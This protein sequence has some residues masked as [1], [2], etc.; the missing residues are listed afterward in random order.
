MS[1]PSKDITS[2]HDVPSPAKLNLFLHVVGQRPDGYHLLQ[3]V[4]TFIDL[5]DFLNFDVRDDG[6][7]NRIDDNLGGG[8]HGAS[9]LKNL[10]PE[11]DLVIKAAKLLQSHTGTK[12]GA[13]IS[14]VKNIP[15]GGGLGG[16]SSNAATTLIALNRLWHTGLNRTQL[17]ELG[18]QLGAD[19]PIFIYGQSAFAQGIGDTFQ[20]VAIPDTNY[21]IVQPDTFVDTSLIFSNQGLTRGQNPVTITDF[22]DWQKLQHQGNQNKSEYF[23]CNNLEP[24][25]I[26]IDSKILETKQ[27]LN[28]LGINA[29]LTGSGACFFVVVATA[30]QAAI[31]QRNISVRI[32]TRSGDTSRIIKKT[33]L[34]SGLNQHPLMHWVDS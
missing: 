7:I 6:A 23:G 4:F 21:L 2:L 20:P 1:V 12:F 3:T 30:Q 17:I 26:K 33:W 32:A 31:L 29:R 14:Y 24:V 5:C 22:T 27:L 8:E 16:G 25:A 15:A 34:C 11:Q 19:I 10:P 9:I 13:D 18:R 28:N